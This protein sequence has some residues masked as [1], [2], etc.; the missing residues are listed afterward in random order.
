MLI[1]VF[2]L[3]FTVFLFIHSRCAHLFT[4]GKLVKILL[5]LLSPCTT[6]DFSADFNSF[7]HRTSQ[8]PVKSSS[9][10]DVESN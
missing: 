9:N 10:K 5:I 1:S 4:R 2:T 7:C 6:E 3:D 8:I